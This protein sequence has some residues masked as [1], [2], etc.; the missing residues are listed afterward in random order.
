MLHFSGLL[1]MISFQE[2]SNSTSDGIPC[3][4]V[5]LL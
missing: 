4:F 2:A 1:E 3:C 5:R